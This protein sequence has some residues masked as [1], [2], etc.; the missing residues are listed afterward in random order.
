MGLCSALFLLKCFCRKDTTFLSLVF[1]F[2]NII[3]RRSIAYI[4]LHVHT[5]RKCLLLLL[6]GIIDRNLGDLYG[7]EVRL[8]RQYKLDHE[9]LVQSQLLVA[10]GEHRFDVGVEVV[11]IRRHNRKHR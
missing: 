3:G 7:G 2:S 5:K 1:K 10:L 4:L 6:D 9:S 8:N 11:L